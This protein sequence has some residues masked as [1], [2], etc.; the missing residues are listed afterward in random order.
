MEG[1]LEYLQSLSQSLTEYRNSLEKVLPEIKENFHIMGSFYVNIKNIF[2]KKGLLADDPYR[3]EKKISDIKPIPNE[4]F[5]ENEKA[6]V[7]S[8]RIAEFEAQLDFLQNFYSF[9]LDSFN[10]A[11]IKRLIQFVKFIKWKNVNPNHTDINT[12]VMGE[13]IQK[14]RSS[15]DSMGVNLINDGIKQLAIY[16]EKILEGLKQLTTYLREDYK[17]LLREAVYPSVD[18]VP[19]DWANDQDRCVREVK[20][21]FA[22]HMRGQPFVPELV[23]EALEEDLTA[24]GAELQKE[25]LKKLNS[26][27]KAANQKQK[28]VDYKGMIMESVRTLASANLPLE[29]ALRKLRENS[30]TIEKK[31]KTFGAK[32][33]NWLMNILGQKDDQRIYVLEFIDAITSASRT[34]KIDFIQFDQSTTKVIRILVNLSTRTSPQFTALKSKEED[35]IMEYQHSSYVK[36]K[37]CLDIMEALDTYFKSEVPREKRNVI[38][39]IKTELTEIKMILAKS[40]KMRHEYVAAKEEVEQL[41]KLGIS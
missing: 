41:K 24:T 19:Q 6:T 35:Q 3:Y 26:P 37:R 8:I 34:E 2:I 18:I 7:L 17:Y 40:N 1:N 15:D 12:R 38:R 14:I 21:S 31:A 11:K 33:K 20:K 36:V 28:V 4:G 25:I 10:L 27:Q 23:K 39:G 5:L 22:Q 29:S 32:F 16:Q 30:N 13:M 9:S